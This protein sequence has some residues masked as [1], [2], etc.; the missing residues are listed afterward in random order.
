MIRIQCQ[1]G[2][3]KPYPFDIL[4]AD[5][6]CDECGTKGEWSRAQGIKCKNSELSCEDCPEVECGYKLAF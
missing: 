5:L 3:T 6:P 4:L 1:C 2:A